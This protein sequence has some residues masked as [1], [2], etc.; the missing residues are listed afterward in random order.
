MFHFEQKR[1]GIPTEI[2]TLNLTRKIINIGH[3]ESIFYC[4]INY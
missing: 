2:N 3:F 4:Q 1:K